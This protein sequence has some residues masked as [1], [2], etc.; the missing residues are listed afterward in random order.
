MIPR[1]PVGLAGLAIARVL[2]G[3]LEQA[4]VGLA[5]MDGMGRLCML[6][7]TLER[8]V[9]RPFT[10]AGTAELPGIYHLYDEHGIDLL[11]GDELPL[12][13]ARL[14][15][16]VV[17][18]II[19]VKAPGCPVRRLRVNAV[20]VPAAGGDLRGSLSVVEDATHSRE[21][22][23]TFGEVRD[24]LVQRV[25]HEIRTP[26]TAILGHAELLDDLPDLPAVAR[27]SVRAIGRS[28]RRLQA[29]ADS[30]TH[31]GERNPG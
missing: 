6:S 23:S 14:G 25:T 10:A 29:V 22:T 13:R 27:E 12:A 8:A 18:A 1:T 17:N 15:Q 31:H 30:V 3:L 20:Q 21:G 4:G 26:L 16:T 11:R 24:R 7:P 19:L 2:P 28:G 9:G 5:A